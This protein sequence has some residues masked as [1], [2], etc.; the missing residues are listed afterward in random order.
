MPHCLFSHEG[1]H[2]VRVGLV[3]VRHDSE[4]RVLCL[5]P[6]RTMKPELKYTHLCTC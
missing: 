3:V 4:A 5:N 2:L 6:N 1:A